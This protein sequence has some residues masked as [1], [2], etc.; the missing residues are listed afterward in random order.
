MLKILNRFL[1][2]NN[3]VLLMYLLLL[4]PMF[5]WLWSITL[6]GTDAKYVSAR[7]KT[8]LNRAVKAAVLAIDKEKLACGSIFIDNSNS[9]A[10]FDRVLTLNLGLREDYAP[11]GA[12]PLQ[13]APEILNYYVCQGPCPYTY[14]YLLGDIK[15]IAYTFEDPGVFALIRVRY[16]HKFTGKIQDIYVYA[17]A[18]VVSD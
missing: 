16:K 14:N 10:N 18:E 9:R 12:S 3:G 1:Q 5:W 6:D 8:A 11:A 4:F 17:A 2:N 7:A 15:N 13:D